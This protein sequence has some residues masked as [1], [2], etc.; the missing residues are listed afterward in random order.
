MK[1]GVMI[2]IEV[3]VARLPGLHRQDLERWISAGLVRPDSAAGGYA[4]REIDIARVRLICELRDDLEVEEGTLPLVLSL[5]DQ[6]YDLRRR[7]RRLRDALDQTVTEDI[8]RD[9]MRR[10]GETAD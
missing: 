8:R 7:M 3:L 6:L 1:S 9:L 10:L 2:G 4:F 5:L